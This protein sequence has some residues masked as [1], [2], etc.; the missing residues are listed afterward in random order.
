MKTIIIIISALLSINS[1]AQTEITKSNISSGGGTATSGNTKIIYTVGE[2]VVQENTQGTVHIS[3]GFINP[4][5]LIATEIKDYTQNNFNVILFPNPAADYTNVRFS[6]ACNYQIKL[7]DIQGK[8]LYEISG[9]GDLRKIPLQNLSAGE[10]L[11][12]VKNIKDRKYQVFKLLK[13]K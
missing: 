13:S 2:F 12:L 6:D 8:E 3:E 9:S 4:D 11:L 1:F 5:M 7:I 10:Y